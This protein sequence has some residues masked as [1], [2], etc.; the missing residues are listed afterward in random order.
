MLIALNN[1]TKISLQIFNS[2]CNLSLGYLLSVIEP[3]YASSLLLLRRKK[4]GFPRRSVWKKPFKQAVIDAPSGFPPVARPAL[5]VARAQAQLLSEITTSEKRT[6]EGRATYT[7]I[8]VCVYICIDMSMYAQSEVL[9]QMY[10]SRV[11]SYKAHACS[12]GGCPLFLVFRRCPLP[13]SP[14]ALSDGQVSGVARSDAQRNRARGTSRHC[15]R[16]QRSRR[17][18]RGGNDS[19]PE[20]QQEDG[21]L[22]VEPQYSSIS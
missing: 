14:P 17:T 9:G 12:T 18:R 13:G 20:S 16:G 22:S 3:T 8:Y 2:R 4:N 6:E 15:R 19:P 10:G 11:E 1:R 21:R 5:Y 7:L